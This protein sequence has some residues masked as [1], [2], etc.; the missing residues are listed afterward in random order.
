MV[1]LNL[2]PLAVL[3]IGFISQLLLNKFKYC[4][5]FATLIL[6]VFLFLILA[7][8]SEDIGID[9]AAY[10][11]AFETLKDVPFTVR[12]NSFEP[13]FVAFMWIIANT[14]G[15]FFFFTTI[16][17][18]IVFGI[19]SFI[20]FK[21]SKNVTLSYFLLFPCNLFLFS[22]SG[23]RQTVAC[24]LCY[25]AFYLWFTSKKAWIVFVSGFLIFVSAGFHKSSLFCFVFLFL[26]KKFPSL[27]TII[28]WAIICIL[29]FV[30]SP[31]LYSMI[32][33]IINLRYAPAKSGRNLTFFVYLFI[34]IASYFCT[35][36]LCENTDNKKN[37]VYFY[38][39]FMI[40]IFQALTNASGSLGRFS[41]YF[42]PFSCLFFPNLLSNF[43]N[44]KYAKYA[45]IIII[46]AGFALYTYALYNNGVGITSYS[47]R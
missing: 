30:G 14:V 18:L 15:S 22:F 29:V 5:L 20:I 13:L 23:I 37:A 28:I 17:Y 33:K 4:K 42:L 3:L 44:K 2:L 6:G 39:F 25:L 36:K 41:F 19:I 31:P 10:K 16:I 43:S 12:Y 8:K 7:L 24:C 35:T 1:F 26:P 32:S 21:A 38:A 9:T 46:L 27:T 40:C 47:F 45:Y 34:F 11:T